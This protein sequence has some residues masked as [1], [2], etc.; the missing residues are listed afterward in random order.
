VQLSAAEYGKLLDQGN[1]LFRAQRYQEALHT[2]LQLHGF[3]PYNP[4]HLSSLA[5]TYS[6][7]GQPVEEALYWEEFFD[8][9]PSPIESCPQIGLAYQKQSKIEESVRAFERCLALD[10]SNADSIYYL[11]HALE[12]KGEL[13]RALGLYQRGLVIA[14][15]YIDLRVGVAR[16]ELN[17][18]RP[19]EA[20]RISLEA[21]QR[22]IDNADALLV[23]G[24][25]A[26]RCGDRAA[27]RVYLEKGS[28]VAGDDPD[29]RRALASL[30]KEESQ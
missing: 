27:A 17:L 20:R 3:D 1:Q 19:Q 30:T 14:P 26:W 23:A 6:K 16:A 28:K 13:E 9:S 7:L 15:N 11:A 8:R 22:S 29:F 18:G 2:Y 12:R 21:L 24:L 4:A 25:A 10:P 5:T